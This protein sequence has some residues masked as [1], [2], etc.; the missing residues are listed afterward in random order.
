[1]EDEDSLRESVR[2]YLRQCGY[3]VLESPN[4]QHA[5]ELTERHPGVIHLLLTDVIMPGMS[6]PELAAQL[7]SRE[8]MV[9]L[10]MSG[11]T[12]DA[13]VDHGV[14]AAGAAFLQKPFSLKT[15]G[16]RVRTLLD[17]QHAREH[18]QMTLG[19]DQVSTSPTPLA[20]VR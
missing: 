7:S 19:L 11:Y 9:V 3:E 6:G 1:V 5:L 12:D 18:K 10:F 4:G 17:S 8:A 15:L 16:A 20:P 14:L 2:E 13:I